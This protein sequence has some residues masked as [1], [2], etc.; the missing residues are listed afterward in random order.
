MSGRIVFV[1]SPESRRGDAVENR[2]IL[3]LVRPQ[4]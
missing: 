3:R 1:L 2:E 4:G